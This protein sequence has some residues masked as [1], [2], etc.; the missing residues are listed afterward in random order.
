MLLCEI[1][2]TAGARP[3]TSYCDS[4]AATAKDPYRGR[5]LKHAYPRDMHASHDESASQGRTCWPGLLTRHARAT[6][7]RLFWYSPASAPLCSHRHFR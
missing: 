6:E 3:C 1:K 4:P 2:R 5:M 7:N